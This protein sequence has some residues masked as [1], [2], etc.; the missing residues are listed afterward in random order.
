MSRDYDL[1]VQICDAKGL[2]FRAGMNSS[3]I[4]GGCR[5]RQGEWILTG[6]KP[7]HEWG[8]FVQR[9]PE[10]SAD[11]GL[12]MELLLSLPE[13]IQISIG[14]S[15]VTVRHNFKKKSEPAATGH[16]KNFPA[17]ICRAWLKLS[18]VDSDSDRS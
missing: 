5:V 12:A 17:I 8:P 7:D 9:I 15:A 18:A 10:W 13:Y 14:Q 11:I 1:D 2:L 6:E 16:R 4:C 3:A